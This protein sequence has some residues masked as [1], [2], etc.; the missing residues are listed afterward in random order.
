MDAYLLFPAWTILYCSSLHKWLLLFLLPRPSLFILLLDIS[1]FYCFFIFKKSF[2]HLSPLPLSICTCLLPNWSALLYNSCV[3]Q[4]N[5]PSP[6]ISV[7]LI[8]ANL[9]I[10][11]I[12]WKTYT[13]AHT[14][15]YFSQNVNTIGERI[16]FLNVSLWCPKH[17]KQKVIRYLFVEF[18]VFFFLSESLPQIK[19]FKNYVN[20]LN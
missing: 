15:P 8:C 11:L 3:I 13:R 10:S 7:F 19:I 9:I 5:N 12:P 1:K 6:F 2:S 17:H 20:L 16:I 14:H 4:N 18:H